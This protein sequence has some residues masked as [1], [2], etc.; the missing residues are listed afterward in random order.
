MSSFF[1]LSALLCLASV[2]GFVN[3]RFLRLPSAIGQVLVA[4]AA[5]LCLVALDRLI[6]GL[7]IRDWSAR[8]LRTEELSQTFLNGALSVLLF[9]GALRIDVSAL[10]SRKITVFL[11]AT[12]GVALAAV[13]F[14]TGMWLTFAAI[15]APL[16]LGWCLVLGAVLAPTDPVAVADVL[17]RVKLPQRLKAV[18]AGESIFNDGA[19]VLIFTVVL[20]IAGGH[21]AVTAGTVALAFLR[22]AGGGFLLGAAT[23]WVAL[24]LMR[25]I[26]DYPLEIM[27]SL[28]VATGSYAV[29]N[30]LE[31]SGP[32]A[33]VVCGLM[34]GSR[35][36]R[37]AMSEET[38]VNLILFWSIID[39]LMNALL[40]L[41]L[42]LEA[43]R[44][45][46]APGIMLAGVVAIPLALVVR[47]VSVVVPVY[48]LHR[49]NPRLWPSAAVLT[50]SGLRGGI[51]VALALSLP[52]TPDSERILIV[53]Y[54]VVLF[55]IVV[56]GLTME[57]VI[58]R[59]F[60]DRGK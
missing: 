58:A 13:L 44:L 7:R 21:A 35:G 22:E 19:G 28:A 10:W 45:N 32:I 56:Q 25:R 49:R 51:S 20:S 29:A 57:R 48:W 16:A 53:C 42:G 8:I 1:L 5:S 12:V 59:A 4:L 41:L 23:G 26:D 14:G 6:P 43:L 52:S 31:L 40:F 60:P 46:F 47:G 17:S 55:T 36:T 39:A 54:I 30:E 34:I 24:E 2:F 27:I 37:L 50:W 3:V 11:L 38:R 9:S 18:M 33:V 15:G